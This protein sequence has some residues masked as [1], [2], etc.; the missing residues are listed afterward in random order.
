M[1]IKDETK[2]GSKGEILPKKPLRELAGISPGD[3]VEIEAE[4]GKLTIRKILT[5]EEVFDLPPIASRDPEEWDI[6]LLDEK[7]RQESLVD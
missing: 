6:R 3:V 1:S 5:I 7:K 4:P 2:V